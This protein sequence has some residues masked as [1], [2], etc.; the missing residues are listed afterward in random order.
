M[1]KV[2]FI[3]LFII[4]VTL[5][6]C[7]DNANTGTSF[8]ASETAKLIGDF[9]SYVDSQHREVDDSKGT[10][11]TKDS[12]QFIEKNLDMFMNHDKEASQKLVDS[13][14]DYRY[15]EKDIEKYSGT[16]YK[17][18]GA[19]ISIQEIKDENLNKTFTL[20]H[21]FNNEA[22]VDYDVLY[23]EKTDLLKED[24]VEFIGLPLMETSF[25]NVSG[26]TTKPF[27]ILASDIEK[28]E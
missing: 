12:L 4:L 20:I 17:D 24:N 25:K 2:L 8:K 7:S 10:S 9:A 21:L 26:G 1:R 28:I 3:A 16:M 14:I 13:S 5:T 19:I 18:K 27:M 6:G 23:I 22:Q 11:I 15:L